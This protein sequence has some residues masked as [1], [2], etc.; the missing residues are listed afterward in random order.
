MTSTAMA[1][2]LASCSSRGYDPGATFQQVSATEWRISSADGS[3]QDTIVLV[4]GPTVD[5]SDWHFA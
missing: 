5:A 1:Q 2:A 4:N 3:I